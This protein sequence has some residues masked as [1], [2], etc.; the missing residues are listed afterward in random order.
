MFEGVVE[1]RLLIQY[2]KMEQSHMLQFRRAFNGNVNV[3][4]ST[5][6]QHQAPSNSLII[7]PF[8]H[9]P[10]IGHLKPSPCFSSSTL[11]LS[12]AFSRHVR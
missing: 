12:N 11:C 7:S 2:I 10:S 6:M 8:Y 3:E 5:I 9:Y 1:K 4:T